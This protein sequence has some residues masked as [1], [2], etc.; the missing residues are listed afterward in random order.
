MSDEFFPDTT[1]IARV[2]DEL[3]LLPRTIVRKSGFE[4]SAQALVC[5]IPQKAMRHS[6]L[7][8]PRLDDGRR[9]IS[10]RIVIHDE[11]Q[12]RILLGSYSFQALRHESRVVVTE[13]YCRY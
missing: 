10:G 6:T 11:L 8:Q 7:C 13:H 4:A 12:V 5:P 3:V 1:D 2:G 9:I